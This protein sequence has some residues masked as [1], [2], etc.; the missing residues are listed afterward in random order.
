MFHFF[1]LNSK[2]HNRKNLTETPISYCIQSTEQPFSKVFQNISVLKCLTVY[3]L[4]ASKLLGIFSLPTFFYNFTY[5]TA[6]QKYS[7]FVSRRGSPCDGH[8]LL[9]L[10][11]RLWNQP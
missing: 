8:L 3:K 5:F 6:F 1:H 2:N 11:F 9:F 10:L 7:T 4:K